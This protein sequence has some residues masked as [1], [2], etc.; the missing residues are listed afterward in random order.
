MDAATLDHLNHR[1][2]ITVAGK[3]HHLIDLFGKFHR[4][5]HKFD[6]HIAFEPST[7]LSVDKSYCGFETPAASRRS[8]D[9]RT[10]KLESNHPDREIDHRTYHE[11]RADDYRRMPKYRT[12]AHIISR[13]LI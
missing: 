2:E 12:P 13:K 8:H 4:I 10:S 9:Q 7:A 11:D 3:Q 1:A 6:V 5:D